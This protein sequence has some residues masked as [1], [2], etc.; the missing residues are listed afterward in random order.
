MCNVTLW[1]YGIPIIIILQAICCYRLEIVENWI[2]HWHIWDVICIVGRTMMWTMS[3]WPFVKWP[4]CNVHLAWDENWHIVIL[5]CQSLS[6][7][8]NGWNFFPC[9]HLCEYIIFIL[10]CTQIEVMVHN[11]INYGEWKL[12]TKC[13]D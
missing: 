10:G 5:K 12:E 1:H 2:L 3:L 11:S 13:K 6:G 8:H 4:C 7:S 9:M